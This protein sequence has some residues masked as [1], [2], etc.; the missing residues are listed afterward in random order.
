MWPRD[1]GLTERGKSSENGCKRS[2]VGLDG[3]GV[4]RGEEAIRE[5]KLVCGEK[6]TECRIKGSC[7]QDVADNG[8]VREKRLYVE[9]GPGERLVIIQAKVDKMKMTGLSGEKKNPENKVC[10]AVGHLLGKGQQ[11]RWEGL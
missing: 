1:E 2:V 6:A 10:A 9:E 7:W 5:S 3:C 8:S 11:W 4:L